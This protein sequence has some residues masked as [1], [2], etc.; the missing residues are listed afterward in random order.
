MVGCCYRAV[1][2]AAALGSWFRLAIPGWIPLAEAVPANA[3]GA[4]P[5]GRHSTP[6]DRAFS[7]SLHEIWA[8]ARRKRT[9]V[10]RHGIRRL[11]SPRNRPF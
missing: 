6:R 7:Q 10:R 5:I 9:L 2:L 11:P 1:A 4:R 8:Q 3:G